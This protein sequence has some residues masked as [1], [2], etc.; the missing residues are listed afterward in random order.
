[1][2]ELDKE[3]AE[4]IAGA[5]E[6]GNVLTAAYVEISGKPH[7]SFYGSTHVHGPDQLAIWVR[8][9]D[10]ELLKTL[11]TNPHMAF[12]YGDV[13]D[14]VYYTFEG[15]GRVSEDQRERIYDEMHPIE[16]QF[17]PDRNGVA[18][19][20]DLDRFTT[21]SKAGKVVQER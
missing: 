9:P 14:R 16:R 8:K 3:V 4:R 12:L 17:D 1:M 6:S 10:S 5:I 21:F 7:L 11:P 15:K 13:S 18:V 20:V 19:I 2:I